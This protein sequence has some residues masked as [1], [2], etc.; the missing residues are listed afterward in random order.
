M[1]LSTRVK[2]TTLNFRTEEIDKIIDSM[3]K[4]ISAVIN[5]N[6]ERTKY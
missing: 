4:R 5:G 2:E 3:D 1:Q 6:G